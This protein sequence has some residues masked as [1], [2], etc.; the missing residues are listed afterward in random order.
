MGRIEIKEAQIKYDFELLDRYQKYSSEILRLSLIGIGAYAFL[1]K[2]GNGDFF[3]RIAN[4]PTSK[5]FSVGSIASFALAVACTLIHR[6]YSSDFMAYHIRFLR[7][8]EILTNPPE[9]LTQADK[10]NATMVA[11]KEKSN[12]NAI[13]QLC[14]VMIGASAIFLGMGTLGLA[15]SL[16]TILF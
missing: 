10:D 7:I 16:L 3:R 14:E 13:A 8:K 5:Y 11:E 1:L 9:W 2:E 4:N 15:I 12:R 6:Y